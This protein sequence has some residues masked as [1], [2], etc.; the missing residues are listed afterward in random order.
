MSDAGRHQR[1]LLRAMGDEVQFHP[2]MRPGL[3]LCALSVAAFIGW[4]M[5]AEIDEITRGEGRVVP[6]SHVQKIQSLEGGILDELL[7]KEGDEVRAGQVVARLDHTRFYSSFMEGSSQ[8][9]SL[10]AAIARLKTEVSGAGQITFPKGID[11]NGE[12]AQAERA[13]FKARQGKKKEA[14]AA[15]QEEVA[16]AEERLTIVEPLVERNA[17]SK[18]EVLR[19]RQDIA[20]LK[21]RMSEI[22]NA[23][24]QEA[25]T[26][27][28]LKS[29]EIAALDQSLLQ[30]KDQLRRTELVSP[31]KG[32]VNDVLVTTQGG[33]IQP[34][35]AIMEILPVDDQLLIEAKIKPKDVAFL[36]T[37]MPAKVKITAYDYTIYGDLDG[38]LEQIS[39]D[40]IE[41]DTTRGKEY[42]YKI[43]VKTQTNHLMHQGK[44]LPIKPGMVAEVAVLSGK[45][46]VISYLLK[47]LLKAKLY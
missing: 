8:A 18:V 28:A 6:T 30:R 40:T 23:Y 5:W 16:M 27:L 45:R 11:A 41:E 14:L 20:A 26:E 24:M 38:S 21:G 25:Y 15:L 39:A 29:A 12:D 1:R 2:W 42:Y 36:A 43:L 19:L 17:V 31:V 4:A 13:L 9:G 33:V 22:N 37:G 32:L 3:W 35:E 44:P 10:R 7:V 34:G 47:P 46:T